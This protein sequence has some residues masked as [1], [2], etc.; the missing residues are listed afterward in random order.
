MNT[1]E[2]NTAHGR[3]RGNEIE[4]VSAGSF[5]Y[6]RQFRTDVAAQ[7]GVCFLEDR[8]HL[9]VCNL[10]DFPDHIISVLGRLVT[11]RNTEHQDFRRI[12][13]KAAVPFGHDLGFC[14]FLGK[15]DTGIQ[16]A[17]EIIGDYQHF[18]HFHTS[19]KCI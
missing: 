10:D 7:D 16:C 19:Q 12:I 4:L 13:H 18:N 15:F 14:A 17:G 3:K 8:A 9:S 6:C 11:G 1:A 2:G 5:K